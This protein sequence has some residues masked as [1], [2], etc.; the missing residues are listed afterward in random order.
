MG[1]GHTLH[2]AAHDALHH[3]ST[4]SLWCSLMLSCIGHERSVCRVCIRNLPNV[5]ARL[6]PRDACVQARCTERRAWQ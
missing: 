6:R 3:L 1:S 2:V 4:I 5:R